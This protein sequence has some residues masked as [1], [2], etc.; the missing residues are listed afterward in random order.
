MKRVRT[1][2]AHRTAS[3]YRSATLAASYLHMLLRLGVSPDTARLCHRVI[4]DEIDHAELCFDTYRAA[5]G[6]RPTSTVPDEWLTHTHDPDAALALRALAIGADEYA[7]AETVAHRLFQRMATLDLA[8]EVAPVVQRIVS[9]E[10]RH[11]GFG[12]QV[13]EELLEATGDEGRMFLSARVE[14][15]LQ[16]V[17][18]E[19]GTSRLPCTDEERQWGLMDGTTYDTLVDETLD[20]VRTRF[21]RIGVSA[22]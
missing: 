12:W 21:A 14:G 7:V 22:V 8:P 20:F 5:G 4:L 13:V 17:R 10:A 1:V 2:W 11:S 18:S 15:Y 16:R 3:E 6:V 19:Y 9:D